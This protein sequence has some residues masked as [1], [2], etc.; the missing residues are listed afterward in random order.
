MKTLMTILSLAVLTGC[1]SSQPIYEMASDDSDT[2]YYE[3]RITDNRYRVG[4][5]GDS[6]A[7]SDAVKDMALLRAAELTL[8]NDYDWFRVVN[9]ETAREES[10]TRVSTGVNSGRDVYRSCGLLGCTTTVSPAYSSINISSTPG[11]NRYSTS[12]EIA[13]GSGEVED[14]TSVYN[15]SEL[16]DYLEKQY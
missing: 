8:L 16:Y 15:A 12:I 9:Q 6:S 3:N 4:Y 14:Q 1:A 5:N 7:S 13:M 11:R 2:G 10:D